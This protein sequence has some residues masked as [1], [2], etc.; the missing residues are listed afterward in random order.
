MEASKSD[1][2]FLLLLTVNALRNMG[3]NHID[4]DVLYLPYARQDRVCASG[5]A[6]SLVV[7]CDLLK[8][9]EV[10]TLR[11]WDLHN[12][13][14]SFEL[15]QGAN[16]SHVSAADIFERYKILANFDLNNLVLCAP[17]QGAAN[18]VN[19]I[20]NLL[21]LPSPIYLDKK[22]DAENGKITKLDFDKSNRP[23]EGTD[24]MIVDDICDGGS[25]FIQAAEV[26]KKQGTR[27]LYLYVTHGIFS[28]GLDEL[29]HY[30]EQIICHHTLNNQLS[31]HPNLTV[32]KD[33]LYAT[34]PAICN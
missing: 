4:L 22:R 30:Y 20:T 21:N 28:K 15:L 10:N 24:V 8:R 7:I 26:L 34:E 6:C 3:I 33:Y 13:K 17:D 2:I 18:R 23:I 19:E 31:N 25:T 12:K 27:R 5:E 11:L 16:A 9:L 14:R 1:H 29:L 32:L